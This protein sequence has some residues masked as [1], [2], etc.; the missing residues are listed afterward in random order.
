LIDKKKSEEKNKFTTV[1]PFDFSHIFRTWPI[2]ILTPQG[3]TYLV[4]VGTII[5]LCTTLENVDNIMV[6][7]IP[8]ESDRI[9]SRLGRQISPL[10]SA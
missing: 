9:P 8:R 5:A 7:P 1:R 6:A 10:G 2:D 4:V 3:R